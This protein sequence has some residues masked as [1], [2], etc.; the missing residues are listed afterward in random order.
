MATPADPHTDQQVAA[1]RDWLWAHTSQ[2]NGDAWDADRDHLE[3]A[4]RALHVELGRPP[5]VSSWQ[6]HPVRGGGLR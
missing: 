2:P 4:A 3:A 6:A 5:V 1:V